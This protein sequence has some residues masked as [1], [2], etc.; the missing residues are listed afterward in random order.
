MQKMASAAKA[1]ISDMYPGKGT[2]Q[3]YLENGI[4]EGMDACKGV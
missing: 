4:F 1:D 3:T 2:E